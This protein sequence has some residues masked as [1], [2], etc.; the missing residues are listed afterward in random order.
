[1]PPMSPLRAYAL[2]MSPPRWPTGCPVCGSALKVGARG[3]RR[4]YCSVNCQQKAKRHRINALR[5]RACEQ[6]GDI[7]D[8]HG[9]KKFCSRECYLQATREKR[10]PA[11]VIGCRAGDHSACKLDNRH[12]ACSECGKTVRLSRSSASP[13]R[14]RCR[15]CRE[16]NPRRQPATFVPQDLTC[17]TCEGEFT[18]KRVGQK[19]CCV[20]HRPP[21][22]GMRTAGRVAASRRRRLR[23]ATGWDGVTDAEIFER[24][25]WKCGICGKRIGRSFK[26]PHPRSKSVDH[27]IPLSE[28]GDD[29][30][31]NKRA[32]HLGCNLSRG[33]RGGGEQ[34]A[35]VG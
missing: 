1:M 22:P 7:V 29:T 9:A 26:A 35:L 3:R 24:D 16:R 14:R 15:E 4:I 12:G 18:Q 5:R 27:V 23:H 6:C 25:R 34:L 19:Y 30:A 20:E 11:P 8:G 17:P 28:G 31:A 33:N 13:D 32:A 10:Q 2:S 21:R